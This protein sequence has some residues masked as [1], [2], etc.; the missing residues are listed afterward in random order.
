MVVV[1]AE[2]VEFGVE[3]NAVGNLEGAVAAAAVASPVGVTFDNV[4]AAKAVA[5]AAG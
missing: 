4:A 5:A 3:R 2:H 1:A